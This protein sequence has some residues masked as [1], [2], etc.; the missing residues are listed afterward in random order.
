MSP[1][2]DSLTDSRKISGWAGAASD[3]QPVLEAIARQYKDLRQAHVL[4]ATRH[5]DAMLAI[6][7]RS[8]HETERDAE[9]A[10]PS[11]RSLYSRRLQPLRHEVEQA[12]ERAA[13]ARAAAEQVDNID[14]RT[15][16]P[17]GAVR[18][19]SG[20]PTD[21]VEYLTHRTPKELTFTAPAGSLAGHHISLNF[22]RNTG[23]QLVVTSRDSRWAAATLVEVHDAL[24]RRK[25]TWLWLRSHYFLYPFFYVAYLALVISTLEGISG[26]ASNPGETNLWLSALLG[27]SLG[28]AG[29]LSGI[30]VRA[31]VPAFELLPAGQ[32]PRL[33][34]LVGTL[35]GVII[36]VIVGVFVNQIS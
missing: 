33:R 20:S 24:K 14:V 9:T 25:P 15:K 8:L 19:A 30:L 28:L 36:A 18:D 32:A 23:A 29:L 6:A 3:L 17:S 22:D 16:D 11:L 7:E 4:E 34:R 5:P 35:V 26:G 10:D 31:F 21:I 27:V 2:D 12:K 13:A 1:L